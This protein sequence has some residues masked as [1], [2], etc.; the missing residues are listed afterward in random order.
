[1]TRTLDVGLE[2]TVYTKA[3][4]VGGLD[5]KI[6]GGNDTGVYLETERHPRNMN[7]LAAIEY[8]EWAD[9]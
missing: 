3:S 7:V 4:F 1:M 2:V 8:I 5:G 6:V 9:E